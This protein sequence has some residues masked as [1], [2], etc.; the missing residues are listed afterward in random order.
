MQRFDRGLFEEGLDVAAERR[1]QRRQVHPQVDRRVGHRH[2][3][4]GRLGEGRHP[5]VGLV[6][7][8]DDVGGGDLVR[9]ALAQG[10]DA[11]HDPALRL[12]R[13]QLVIG[14]NGEVAHDL[15]ATGFDGGCGAPRMRRF[16]RRDGRGGD[17]SR[18]HQ[19]NE[20]CHALFFPRLAD[21]ARHDARRRGRLQ[22]FTGFAATAKRA[23]RLDR[24]A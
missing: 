13:A 24:A 20:T 10:L 4:V 19:R 8:P 23:I 16:R 1:Q 7:V 22:G 17:E 15:E 5:R 11:R 2:M 12:R 9:E 6:A 3:R 14:V 18:A 21:P